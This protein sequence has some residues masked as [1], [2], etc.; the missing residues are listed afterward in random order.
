VLEGS[1]L[2]HSDE[3]KEELVRLALAYLR[4]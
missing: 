4:S 3:F 2:L 1:P